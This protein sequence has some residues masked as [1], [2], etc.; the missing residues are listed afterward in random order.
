[1]IRVV[2]TDKGFVIADDGPGVAVED[3]ERI[4]PFGYT[5]QAGGTGIELAIV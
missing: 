3:R 4:V 1:L 2:C 5:D